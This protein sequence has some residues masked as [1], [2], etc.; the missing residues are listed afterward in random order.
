MN[1]AYT[2]KE[3]LEEFCAARE[4]LDVVIRWLEVDAFA[5]LDH[6]QIEAHIDHAGRDILRHLLQGHLNLRAR[7]E[8]RQAEV[9]GSDG[10]IRRLCRSGSRALE[11]LFGTV[12]VERLS[13]G[14]KEAGVKQLCPL[15]AELKLPKQKYSHGLQRRVAEEAVKVSFDATVTSIEKYTGGSVPKRQ[16]EEVVSVISQDFEDFYAQEAATAPVAAT[17]AFLIL[18]EDGKGIVM[19]RESLREQTRRSAEN[20]EQKVKTRLSAGEKRDRKRMA[21]V[22]TVYDIAPHQR[23]AEAIM[24]VEG[25]AETISPPPRPEHKRVWA[26][27]AR[28]SKR[29][30]EEVFEEAQRRDP[31]HQRTWAMLVD[32]QPQQLAQIKKTATAK[33]VELILI[34]DFIHVLE[35]LWKAAYCLHAPGTEEAEAWVSERALKLL[36]G[37]VSDVAAGMRR[38]ATLNKLSR[39]K[40]A[41]VDR[42]ANYLLNHR[43]MLRYDEYLALGLPIATGVIEGACR[44]LIAD[45]MDIT[46]A[47]WGLKTAEAVLK[48]RSLHSSGDLDA[49]WEFHKAREYE[50][51]HANHYEMPLAA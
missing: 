51:L 4:Q 1:K 10:I 21:T 38:S 32:G 13:Y 30:T 43:D 44:H 48:L 35:Y 50:R 6:G 40:R 42:C 45:R 17:N 8:I 28:D 25:A 19:R 2:G 18:S 14:A 46:G 34:L 24:Q 26:S 41:P 16:A 5:G 15:D 7:R 3:G 20:T 31:N 12:R 36:K 37:K 9:I 11:S 22:A 29:V 39:K 47:R 33:G 49:Y 23:T 27:L